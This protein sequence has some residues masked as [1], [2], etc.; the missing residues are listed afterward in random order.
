M[1]RAKRTL[2]VFLVLGLALAALFAS[3]ACAPTQAPTQ[4]AEPT[5]APKPTSIRVTVVNNTE[6]V[7]NELYVSATAADA[8]GDDHLGSTSILK[9]NGSFEITLPAYDFNNYDIRVV[10]E[11]EDEYLFERVPMQ[12]GAKVVIAFGDAGLEASS[13]L[14]DGSAVTVTG[15]LSSGSGAEPADAPAGG[16][17]SF[18]V[19]NNSDFD[20]FAIYMGPSTGAAADDIDIL[21]VVLAARDETRVEGYVEGANARIDEWTLFVRD[22]DGDES[23]SYDAFNPWTLQYVV[24]YWNSNTGG[25]ECAFHY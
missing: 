17:Y 10:D 12:N 18:T 9:K 14:A 4:A 23:V 13:T 22:T 16:Y 6:Y 15:N 20:I 24:V 19:Q 11:D 8:W 5:E 21:P 1:N 7:F 25:W 3:A 2:R